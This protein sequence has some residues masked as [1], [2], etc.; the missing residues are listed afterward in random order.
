MPI[1]RKN[2]NRDE[3]MM[4]PTGAGTG[5]G[6]GIGTTGHHYQGAP[7]I[8]RSGIT[9]VDQPMTGDYATGDTTNPDYLPPNV[10]GTGYGTGGTQRPGAT[11]IHGYEGHGFNEPPPSTN[12]MGTAG[13][14]QPTVPPSGTLNNEYQSH[15]GKSQRITGKIESA[16][17]TAI[18][19]DT[20]KAKG[21]QKEREA[22]AMKVQGRELAEA[23][24]LE[25]E[26]IM[27][28]D[29]AVAHGAH[30]A[31]KDLGA[32]MNTNTRNYP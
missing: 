27:R 31:N 7:G 19:S 11:G 13:M 21:L 30:P 4:A 25:R 18:G 12:P 1:L 17:G 16:I 24:R 8:D 22:N 26:A 2:N 15:G 6:T 3:N 9:P 20:L 14:Q 5:T 10:S 29:R 32:G 23:E 28:R